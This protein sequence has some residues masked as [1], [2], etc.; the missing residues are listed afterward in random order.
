[1][2]PLAV[3]LSDPESHLSNNLYL[4]ICSKVVQRLEE[5]EKLLR[6]LFRIL[7]PGGFFIL[8]TDTVRI[9]RRASDAFPFG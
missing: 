9:Y 4:V 5:P 3:F 1:M 7:R 8:S 6:E 2:V